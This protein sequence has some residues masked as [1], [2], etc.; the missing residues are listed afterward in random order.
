MVRPK[1]RRLPERIK[2]AS[3]PLLKITTKPGSRSKS[4]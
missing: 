3:K 2:L 4:H 1:L